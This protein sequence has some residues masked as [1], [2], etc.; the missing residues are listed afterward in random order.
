MK[1]AKLALIGAVLS[2]P[3]FAEVKLLVDDHIKVTAINGEAITHGL[4]APVK[5]EFKLAGGQHIITARYERLFDI[6]RG[7]HDVLRSKDITVTASL[8]D[9][10]TYR[11]VMPNQPSR[12]Q[13][14]KE[15]IKAPSLAIV[16]GDKVVSQQSATSTQ[17]GGVFAGL[18]ALL[19]RGDGVASNQKVVQAVQTASQTS[20]SAQTQKAT[21]D[22]FMELWLSA[23]ESEREKIRQ[24]V[25]K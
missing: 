23:D 18:G 21:L 19:G 1:L 20:Q 14:A 15:Y 16:Q 22:K 10:Q 13:D 25:Q 11:L 9:D 2:M 8:A 3:A 12:Y 6:S 7:D 17:S 4:F 5:Q 24:W